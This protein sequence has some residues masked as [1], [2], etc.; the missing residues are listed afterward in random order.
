MTDSEK[1]HLEIGKILRENVW[2]C[3]QNMQS[4]HNN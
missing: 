2:E 3:C 4:K 1:I